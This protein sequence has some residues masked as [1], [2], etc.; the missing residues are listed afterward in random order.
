MWTGADAATNNN[1][2]HANNWNP[3][4][5]PAAGDALVFP[6]G[7]TG[8]ALNSNNNLT[9]GTGFAS[10]TIQD[11]GY[12]IG[13]NAVALTGSIDASQTTGGSTVNLP[14]DFG[15]NP[16]TVKVDNAG[17]IL[18]L[19]GVISGSGGLTKPGSGEL[20]LGAQNTFTGTT[21]VSAGVLRVDGLV[22]GAVAVSS[23][24]TLGGVGTVGSITTTG[25]TLKPGDAAPG[26]LTDT[27]AL[28]LNS[29]ST[30][31]VTLN[32]NTVFSQTKVAGAIDLAGA[33]LSTT[34]GFTPSGQQS[35]TII[36]NTGSAAITGTFAGLAQG[37]VL[38]VAGGEQFKIS[39]TGGDGNDV[40]LTHLADT[41][42]MISPVTGSPVFGQSVTL[43]ATVAPVSSGFGTPTGTVDFKNGAIDLGSGTLNS[44]G[45]ATVNTTALPT[46]ANAVT[47]VYSGDPTFA[48][49]TAPSASVTIGQASTTTTVTSTSPNP[50]LI[51]GPVT[52]TAKVAVVSPGAGTP[53]GTVQFFSGSTSLGNGTFSAGV[54]T[55]QT[56]S[57]PLGANA[58]T[59][60]YSGSTNFKASTS[61]AVNQQVNS[62]TA[63]IAL[64]V[65]NTNPF[66]FQ[67]VTLTATVGTG[68]GTG[69]PTGTVTF[70]DING[71]NL[72]TSTL[73]NGTATLSIFTLPIGRES[74]TAVYS[75]DSNFS[76]VTSATVPMVVG[77]PTELFVNQVY[78]DAIGAPAGLGAGLWVAQINGGYSPRLV[79]RYILESP[80]A[81]AQAVENVYERFLRRPA[82]SRELTQAL[83]SRQSSTTLLVNI[84]S[85]REYY[86]TQGGGTI[87]G[88]LTALGNDWFGQPFSPAVQKRLAGELK[89]GVPR[90]Q[91]VRDVITSPSGIASEINF[92]YEVILERPADLKG[93]AHF[94]PLIKR[95][96]VIPVMDALFGSPEFAA[97]FVNI[98]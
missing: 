5:V 60:A 30:Y 33:T 70:T 89:R 49:S 26:V 32:S 66:G 95:G 3:A 19:G 13:G 48:M 27:G 2:D 45:V 16:G 72:G 76:S 90:S 58:I 65:S 96:Q 52:L 67:T 94:T 34:L 50:S 85:S 37:A 75:G 7:L 73:T 91:V 42:T 55:L 28:T 10:L 20:D 18:T 88:F 69:T 17:A 79:A 43:T 56:S 84:L 8:A 46:G 4:A 74:I 22:T 38:T 98:I 23:G 39:Y 40:V 97:K 86:R 57:L 31:A 81:R 53:S 29:A 12:T 54:A 15:S 93:I 51:G 9:A 24:A 71:T 83:T 82:T 35:F 44:S 78:L 6:T 63:T 11:Q 68:T 36:N 47:A 80:Q 87:G 64:S 25:A 59:A 77:S 62:R 92:I 1:W 14:V 61:P 21:T 41:T